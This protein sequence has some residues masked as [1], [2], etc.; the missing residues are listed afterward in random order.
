[1]EKIYCNCCECGKKIEVFFVSKDY[2]RVICDDC[3]NYD[4]RDIDGSQI[5]PKEVH[6]VDKELEMTAPDLNAHI[7]KKSNTSG[8]HKYAKRM[9]KNGAGPHHAMRLAKNYFMKPR[10]L[11]GLGPDDNIGY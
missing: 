6:D 5:I 11:K 10:K 8:V 9:M 3:I 1:M 2:S 7:E 4:D